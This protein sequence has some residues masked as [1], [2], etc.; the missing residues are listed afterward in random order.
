MYLEYVHYFT[1]REESEEAVWNI[2]LHCVSPQRE[3]CIHGLNE[4]PIIWSICIEVDRNK[5]S[6]VNEQKHQ[7]HVQIQPES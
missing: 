4:P 2:S 6:A 3:H 1:L 5:L 7:Q